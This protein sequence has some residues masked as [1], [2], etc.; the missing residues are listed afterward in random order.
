MSGRVDWWKSREQAS[1]L[2]RSF[3]VT[4]EREGEREREMW[5]GPLDWIPVL[6]LVLA[7]AKGW[8]KERGR[9]DGL[10]GEREDD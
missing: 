3:S 10:M 1:G 9:A 5:R 6:I 7:L 2:N 4:T 8:M